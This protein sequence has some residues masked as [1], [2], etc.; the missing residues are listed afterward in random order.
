MQYLKAELNDKII[1]YVEEIA[2]FVEVIGSRTSGY[3]IISEAEISK[4]KRFEVSDQEGRQIASEL[5]E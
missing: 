2:S 3:L 1:S 4:I 5:Q